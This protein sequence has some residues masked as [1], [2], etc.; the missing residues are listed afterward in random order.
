MRNYKELLHKI[1]TLVFDYDGVL[2]NGIVLLT[3]NDEILRTSNVK[4]AFALQYAVDN[5]YRIAILTRGKSNVIKSLF[6]KM[7]V[8]DIFLGVSDKNGLFDTYLEENNLKPDEVLFMGDDLPDYQVLKRVAVPCCPA[9]AVEEIKN[10]S[11]YISGYKGGQGCV[12]D[13]IEQVMKVQGKWMTQE[14]YR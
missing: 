5:G 8:Q 4:D 14:K 7:G 1:T 12:R 3:E 9:D 13:I 6:K 2:T 10:V 11:V